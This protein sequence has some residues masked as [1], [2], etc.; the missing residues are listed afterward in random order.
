MINVMTMF[1]LFLNSAVDELPPQSD[2]L[3]SRTQKVLNIDLGWLRCFILIN[4][5]L[6]FGAGFGLL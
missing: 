5:I 6:C 4:Q 2:G 1:W 3:A